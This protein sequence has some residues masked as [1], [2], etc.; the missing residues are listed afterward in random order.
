EFDTAKM[1]LEKALKIYPQ[2]PVAS[3]RMEAV[4]DLTR[5]QQIDKLVGRG[6]KQMEL[7]S[8]D[9]ARDTFEEIL[10][11]E[12]SN[13]TAKMVIGYI[14]EK[15]KVEEVRTLLNQGWRTLMMDRKYDE[16][17]QIGEKV[18]T[19]DPHNSEARSLIASARN[20]KTQQ[21]G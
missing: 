14:E 1:A 4:H 7:G 12:P 18:L 6:N 17:I 15:K 20:E 9:F 16:V 2:H 3:K 19:M 8:Y 11:L 21:G 10:K 13:E 5:K